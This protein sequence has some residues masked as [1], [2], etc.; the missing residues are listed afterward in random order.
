L[1]VADDAAPFEWV[2]GDASQT[3]TL[4]RAIE[5]ATDRFGAKPSILVTSAARLEV[6]DVLSLPDEEWYRTF[7]VNVFGTMRAIRAV[8]PGMI[9]RGGGA[10]VTVGS[11]DSVMAEQGLVSYCASKGAVLQLTRTIA[12]DHARQGIRANCVIM[13]VT[14]TPFFRRHLDTA[15]DPVQFVK[16]RE[17]RQPM[18]KLLQAGEVAAAIEFL[19]SPA[20]SGI[21]GAA[22]AVDGGITTSFDFRTGRE[23]A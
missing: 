19:A 20:A 3:A 9:E 18:G 14:D 12:M 2:Q 7:E 4:E 8:L 11:I 13:G 17:N 15:S 6:G 23:G 5:L 21:T 10:I 22:I 1:P 16:V